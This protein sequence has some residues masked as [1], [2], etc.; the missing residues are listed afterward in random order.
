MSLLELLKAGNVADFNATRSQRNRLDLYACELENAVLVGVDLSGANV[1]KSDLTGADLTDSNLYK[2]DLVGIDGENIKLVGSLAHK[3][4]LNEAYM[5]GGDFSDGDFTKANFSE[6]VVTGSKGDGIRLMGARLKAIDA[7]KAV[8]TDADLSESSMYQANFE[9]ADLRR[10][11]MT[12]ASGAEANF[13]GAQLDNILATGAKLPECKMVGTTLTGARMDG[14]NLSAADLTNADLTAA[15]L[16]RANLTGAI[17]AGAKLAG[18]CF[19]DACLDDVDLAGVDL[20]DVDMTGIDPKALG[21]TDDQIASL[22]AFGADVDPDAPLRVTDVATAVLGEV[23]LSMWVNA[24]GDEKSSVRWALTTQKKDTITG[25]LPLSAEGVL[26]HAAVVFEGAFMLLVFQDR[27]G[28]TSLVS[29]PVSL[30]GVPGASTVV[31]LGYAP[32]VQPAVQSDG[33]SVWIWGINRRG[34][35]LVIHKNG[36]E[37]FAPVH[38]EKVATARGIYGHTH[39]VMASKGGA[40]MP[41][42]KKGVLGPLRTPDAF[43]GG[44]ATAVPAG[45]RILCIWNTPARGDREPGGLRFAYLAKRGTPEIEILTV[46]AGVT[47]LQAVPEPGQPG[48]VRVA[49][50]ETVIGQPATV[51]HVVIPGGAMKQVKLPAGID[52]DEVRFARA[53]GG[54]GALAITTLEEGLVVV[55]LDN[56]LYGRVGE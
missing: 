15:D 6:A 27:P 14:V 53:A 31:P 42:G 51:F 33:K 10:A 24:D 41:L 26:A 21:L 39:P 22:S 12:E 11:D 29:Y 2:T 28:G 56:K 20:A 36:E 25:V 35:T 45:D 46:E 5:D 1:A 8:W 13:S 7:R 32:S 9:G 4:R 49:W 3:V 48:A 40:L 34:P 18:A 38:F 43:K 37:G 16:S 52:V 55:G 17:L 47:S 30:E 19:A 50:A 54:A 44:M 23:A